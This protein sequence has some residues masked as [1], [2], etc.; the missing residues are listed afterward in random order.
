[1]MRSHLRTRKRGQSIVMFA[2]MLAAFMALMAIGLDVVGLYA[3]RRM[4]QAVADMAVIGG[5][6]ELDG[7]GTG[8]TNA[9]TVAQTII[10]ANGYTLGAAPGEATACINAYYVKNTNT[11]LNPPHSNSGSSTALEVT[12][13]YHAPTIFAMTMGHSVANV[14][15]R[16]VAMRRAINEYSIYAHNSACNNPDGVDLSGG[17]G[18]INGRIHSNSELDLGSGWT[19][20][21]SV[22]YD[23]TRMSASPACTLADSNDAVPVHAGWQDWPI[24]ATVRD[25]HQYPCDWSSA[26]AV[27]GTVYADST[28][29]PAGD[30]N[31]SDPG[32]WWVDPATKLQL[33]P[34]VYCVR[35]GGLRATGLGNV[36]GNGVTFVLSGTSSSIG[37]PPLN[38]ADF[39]L[40]ADSSFN[41]NGVPNQML[42][43]VEGTGGMRVNGSGGI[44]EGWIYAPNGPVEF[45][46]G[47]GNTFT[48]AI[49]AQTVLLTGSGWSFQGTGPNSGFAGQLTE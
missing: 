31:L 1:M 3:H 5:A 43:F 44:W 21:G 45:L 38:A 23:A 9:A 41:V 13:T 11:C 48:G 25:I 16:A 27:T 10:T 47:G 32:A 36:T 37:S 49:F 20:T 30:F 19:L 14:L 2:T 22:T 24:N 29:I 15:G 46:G 42:F 39:N 8:A 33:R 17:G 34:G 7:S 26:G 6:V 35:D 28:T 4:A 40:T 12:V 18:I